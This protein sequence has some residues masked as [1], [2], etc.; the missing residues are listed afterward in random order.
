M[1]IAGIILY[2]VITTTFIGA[3]TLYYIVNFLVA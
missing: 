3:H 1:N 2:I